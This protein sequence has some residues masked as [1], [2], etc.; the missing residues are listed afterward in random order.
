MDELR[1]GEEEVSILP[2]NSS[3][4]SSS[5][6][7][8]SQFCAPASTK[9]PPTRGSNDCNEGFSSACTIGDLNEKTNK[10]SKR[11]TSRKFG[12]GC[13]SFFRLSFTSG[14]TNIVSAPPSC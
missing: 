8:L 11:P 4:C 3:N 14:E 6:D 7:A 1:S 12:I 5:E 10:N 9:A 13:P 2:H